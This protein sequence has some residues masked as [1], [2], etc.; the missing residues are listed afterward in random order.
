MTQEN[1]RIDFWPDIEDE[2]KI[3]LSWDLYQGD[4]MCVSFLSES[5]DFYFFQELCNFP[6]TDINDIRG[7]LEHFVINMIEGVHVKLIERKT[8][9]WINNISTKPYEFKGTFLIHT[10]LENDVKRTFKIEYIYEAPI[11]NDYR[12]F[13]REI[14]IDN[15]VIFQDHSYDLDWDN[16]YW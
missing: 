13:I 7:T 8:T 11:G 9:S 2:G 12:D 15:D 16:K 5:F 1:T 10:L 14:K 4:E 6:I 3:I